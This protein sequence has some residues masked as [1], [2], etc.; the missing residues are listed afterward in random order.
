MVGTNSNFQELL[1]LPI[2]SLWM[3]LPTAPKKN[4]KSSFTPLKNDDG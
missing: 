1:M 2:Y 4:K 3:F